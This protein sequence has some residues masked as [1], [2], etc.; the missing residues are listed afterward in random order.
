MIIII[1]T[2]FFRLAKFAGENSKLLYGFRKPA[3][4]IR[5]AK[6]PKTYVYALILYTPR[7][8]GLYFWF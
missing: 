7:S 3:Q 5:A 8:L 4:R 1:Q 2:T 6:A